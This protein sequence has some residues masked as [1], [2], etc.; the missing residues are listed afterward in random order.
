[1]RPSFK[2]FCGAFNKSYSFDATA[3]DIK[4]YFKQYFS[5]MPNLAS[6]DLH[7][8]LLGS[9][10]RRD[11][12]LENKQTIGNVWRENGEDKRKKL[13]IVI[14][15]QKEIEMICVF[16]NYNGE[17]HDID[18]FHRRMTIKAIRSQ[19]S[20]KNI[21]KGNYKLLKIVDN[22]PDNLEVS[23]DDTISDVLNKCEAKNYNKL[24]LKISPT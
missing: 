13:F 2:V 16:V 12:Y 3:E 17:E 11:I 23:N 18:F 19:I 8:I 4:L 14:P 1:V 15:K 10:S 5:R 22:D 9:G 6:D 7:V 21:F 20:A 24:Y